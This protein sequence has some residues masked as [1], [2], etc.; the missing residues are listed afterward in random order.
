MLAALWDG[1]GSTF[2]TPRQAAPARARPRA[3]PRGGPAPRQGAAR[4]APDPCLLASPRRAR[5]RGFRGGSGDSRE[6]VWGYNVP[7]KEN[8]FVRTSNVL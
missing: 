7:D 5:P 3:R 6:L 8:P 4:A 2:P 1:E